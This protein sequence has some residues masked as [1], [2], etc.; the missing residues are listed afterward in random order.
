MSI[1][2][3]AMLVEMNIS[4][5]TGQR[6]DRAATN[7]TTMDAGATADAGQFKKNLMAGTTKRKA[8]AD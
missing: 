1:S 4:V 3:A 7:K 6:V 8:I 2:N 5:W